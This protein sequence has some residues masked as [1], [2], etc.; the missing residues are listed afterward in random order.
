MGKKGVD[1]GDEESAFGH[2]VSLCITF[3]AV[4]TSKYPTSFTQHRFS[5]KEM[6]GLQSCVAHRKMVESR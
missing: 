5:L 4:K 1:V 2:K 6:L 3:S